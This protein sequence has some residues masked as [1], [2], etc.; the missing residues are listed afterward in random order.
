MAET[1]IDVVRK[2]LLRFE[3]STGFADFATFDSGQAI[4]FRRSLTRTVALRSGK[5]LSNSTVYS[6]VRAVQDFLRWLA[7]EPGY[8]SRNQLSKPNKVPKMP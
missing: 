6:T 7:R 3:E 4:A 8:E 2:A 1:T 5:I